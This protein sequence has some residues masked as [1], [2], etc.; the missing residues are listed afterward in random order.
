MHDNGSF[1]PDRTAQ[2]KSDDFDELPDASL[3]QAGQKVIKSLGRVLLIVGAA[4][5]KYRSTNP[6]ERVVLNEIFRLISEPSSDL[7]WVPVEQALNSFT[8]LGTVLF[9][10]QIVVV[11]VYQDCSELKLFHLSKDSGD[12]DDDDDDPSG[13]GQRRLRRPRSATGFISNL[14]SRA[15]INLAERIGQVTIST[16]IGQKL[17]ALSD[18]VARGLYLQLESALLRACLSWRMPT[19]PEPNTHFRPVFHGK[20]RAETIYS[21]SDL[22]DWRIL[23]SPDQLELVELSEKK[24]SWPPGAVMTVG[25]SNL[26]C[27]NNKYVS[28]DWT[29]TPRGNLSIEVGLVESESEIGLAPKRHFYRCLA[30]FHGMIEKFHDSRTEKSHYGSARILAKLSVRNP[31]L[32]DR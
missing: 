18:F 22:I 7:H 31:T 16:G 21:E 6:Q 3:E 13:G 14:D 25:R 20:V 19:R 11:D 4:L 27:L 2:S 30:D 5:Q 12:D 26:G 17:F 29:I 10:Y 1:D 8:L 24:R 23:G 9:G 28:V 32:A 15:S